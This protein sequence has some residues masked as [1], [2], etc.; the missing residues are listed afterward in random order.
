MT[1]DVAAR[2]ADAHGAV[3]NT[4]TLV[5]ACAVVGY[6]HPDLTLHAGQIVQ[7]FECDEDLDLALLGAD[8]DRLQAALMIA[9]D[10]MRLEDAAAEGLN[11]A[12]AG[13]AGSAAADFLARHRRTVGGLVEL[14]RSTAAGCGTLR[15]TLWRVVDTKVGAAI[16][17][18]ERRAGERS[19]WLA[20]ARTVVGS[21]QDRSA[22][23]EIVAKAVVPYVDSDIR[24]DWVDAM[25]S[26]R[27]SAVGAYREALNRLHNSAAIDFAI[28]H[29]LVP[30]LTGRGEVVE[31]PMVGAF[32]QQSSGR[33][34]AIP[35]PQGGE[36]AIPPL[37]DEGIASATAPEPS[38]ASP[39]PVPPQAAEVPMTAAPAGGLLSG[40][41]ALPNLDGFTSGL[42]EP[43]PGSFAGL[44]QTDPLGSGPDGG[45]PPDD[46]SAEESDD[47]LK[48]R[49]NDDAVGAEADADAEADTDGIEIG[50]EMNEGDDGGTV[51]S[52]SGDSDTGGES[53]ALQVNPLLPAEELVV[54][55]A[56]ESATDSTGGSGEVATPCEIAADELPQVGE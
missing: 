32:T 1:F 53:S 4:Q 22:A 39:A 44:S 26:A 8:C 50:G 42:A 47:H 48:K 33:E 45:D 38:P 36:R 16:A 5:S 14:M 12:W 20:A 11:A 49:E 29:H 19:A 46:D 15:D 54:P 43:L 25:R 30:F 9:E 18:D 40:P 3:E 55:P 51:P 24:V 56:P 27:A 37:P 35:P 10:A 6:Q 7:W 17:I 2:L 31:S 23:A 21:A 52:D 13:A 34:R 41:A 28:P